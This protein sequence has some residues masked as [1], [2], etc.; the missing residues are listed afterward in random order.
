VQT[1]PPRRGGRKREIGA[2]AGR[3]RAGSV[4]GQHRQSLE[5]LD[6]LTHN[7]QASN[8]T[9]PAAGL[10]HQS[11]AGTVERRLPSIT[12]PVAALARLFRA[13]VEF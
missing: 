8:V 7:E 3:R 10:R 1:Q 2:R 4:A 11:E 6:V 9:Q 13:M 12:Q 5:R